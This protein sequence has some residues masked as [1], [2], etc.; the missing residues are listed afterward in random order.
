MENINIKLS[1]AG[2]ENQLSISVSTI[3]ADMPIGCTMDAPILG[4]VQ[5]EQ[6]KEQ[7]LKGL[8]IL[9]NLVLKVKNQ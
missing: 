7:L 4:N 8:M 3:Y 6:L 2:K 5:S 9:A 1:K